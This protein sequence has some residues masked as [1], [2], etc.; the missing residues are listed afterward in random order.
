MIKK[1]ASIAII[2]TILC[3][4]VFIY[5]NTEPSFQVITPARNMITS[6][7]NIILSM[8]A[9]EGTTVKI[10]VFYNASVVKNKENYLLSQDPIEL[11]IG[12]LQ[13][14]WAEVELKKGLSK[15]EFTALYK[16]GVKDVR[17]RFITIKNIEDVK[18]LIEQSIEKIGAT[19]ST[20]TLN[21][22]VNIEG[23]L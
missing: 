8:I 2:L 7:R 18:K 22:I 4:G 13:R 16:N 17:T 3:S 1:L 19:S 11:K 21:R 14:G 5:A 10:E 9:P 12:A 20:D 23:T 15:I 6:D